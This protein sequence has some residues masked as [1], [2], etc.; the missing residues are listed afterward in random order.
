MY[1]PEQFG[2]GVDDTI[3]FDE[4]LTYLG[5]GCQK[6]IHN[7]QG[8]KPGSGGMQAVVVQRKKKMLL[9]INFNNFLLAKK[10]PFHADDFLSV[11]VDAM[12][13]PFHRYTFD[14]KVAYLEKYLKGLC[15]YKFEKVRLNKSF[16]FCKCFDLASMKFYSESLEI[17]EWLFVSG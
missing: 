2:F 4:N 8:G 1:S 3:A 11:K 10:T 12:L 9:K 7:I 17:F 16:S 15:N 14:Q 6:A 5:I 13:K